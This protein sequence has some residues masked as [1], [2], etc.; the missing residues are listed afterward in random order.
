[1]AHNLDE[2][3][4]A[5]DER[6]TFFLFFGQDEEMK[7][8][9]EEMNGHF[10]DIL[11]PLEPAAVFSVKTVVGIFWTFWVRWSGLPFPRTNCGTVCVLFP[12]T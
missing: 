2:P 3:D 11:G 7:G 10:L 4:H 5:L 6:M 1:M 9:D 8:Q 12:T